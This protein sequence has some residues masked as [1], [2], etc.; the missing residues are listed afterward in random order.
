[1]FMLSDNGKNRTPELTK[2]ASNMYGF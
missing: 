1:L 2:S